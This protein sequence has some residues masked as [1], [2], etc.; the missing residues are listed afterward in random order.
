MKWVAAGAALFVLA[1]CANTYAPPK[2]LAQTRS[3][4]VPGKSKAE[5]LMAARRALVGSG[6]QVT[7]FDDAA[8]IISSAPHD[9]H[10]TPEAADCGT[11]MGI[12]YLKDVRTTTRVAFGVIASDGKMEVRANIEGEY[13]PG[14]AIQNITLTCV[15]RGILEQEMVQRVLAGD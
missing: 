7:A 14:S 9:L 13:K 1:G 10:L 15:S 3:V 5:I 8:G 11:T 12:D 2:T 4:A 6:Y